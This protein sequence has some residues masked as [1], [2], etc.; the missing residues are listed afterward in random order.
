MLFWKIDL[1]FVAQSKL[2]DPSKFQVAIAPVAAEG[3]ENE[4][5][6]DKSKEQREDGEEEEEE[7]MIFGLFDWVVCYH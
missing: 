5:I 3:N 7:E 2:Q 4:E 1:T 6:I